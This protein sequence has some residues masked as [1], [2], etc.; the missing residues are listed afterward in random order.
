M[1][2]V[3]LIVKQELVLN[4]KNQSQKIDNRADSTLIILANKRK[5]S[6]SSMLTLLPA[7]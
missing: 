6:F 2:I 1:N 7:D 5:Y 4:L 3:R